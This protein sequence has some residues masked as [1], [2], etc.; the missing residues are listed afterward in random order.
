MTEDPLDQRSLT[1]LIARLS[2]V[3]NAE[4]ARAFPQ[5]P[6]AAAQPGLY[7]WWVDKP[8]LDTLFAAFERHL[9]PLVYA[10]Q[11]GAT[12]SRARVER[13]A[14]LRSRISANHLNGNVRSST[15]RRTLTAV[16]LEPLRL[17]LDRPG[18]LAATDNQKVSDW[19]RQHLRVVIAAYPDRARLSQIEGEVLRRLD[20]PLNL[21]GMPPTPIRQRLT[22]LRARLNT[23]P[24]PEADDVA[25]SGDFSIGDNTLEVPQ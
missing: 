12:S 14:T 3:G 9:P 17:R 7:A 6:A 11:A 8:G 2:D 22:R 5:D 15:F 18:R 10:G 4:P 16:L 19:M 20:P 1:S 13:S 24:A 25:T 23:P 21:M